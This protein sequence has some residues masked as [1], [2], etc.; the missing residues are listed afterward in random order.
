M[1]NKTNI[2]DR[3]IELMEV[4]PQ[5]TTINI[6]DEEPYDKTYHEQEVI[7]ELKHHIG[8]ASYSKLFLHQLTQL[9]GAHYVEINDLKYPYSLNSIYW[10]LEEII[11]KKVE[12]RDFRKAGS[13]LAG[14][15]L[16]HVH[17]SKEF[18]I[19]KNA[20]NHFKRTYPSD[21]SIKAKIAEIIIEHPNN[22]PSAVFGVHILMESISSPQKTGEW[23]IFQNSGAR[24]HFI[25]LDL[26][27]TKE[28]K[29]DE[30]LYNLIKS[31]LDNSFIR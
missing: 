2:R 7:S 9:H 1:E 23:I 13:Y 30:R 22:N 28:D 11:N 12:F 25:C 26:H 21:E 4:I 14:K 24:F 17:H 19:S 16:F 27:N 18:Y 15:S 31:H 3:M 6:T 10:R 20:I 8:N 29:N 5:F